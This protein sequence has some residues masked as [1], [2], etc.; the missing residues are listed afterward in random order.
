MT[1]TTSISPPQR[2]SWWNQTKT[3]NNAHGKNIIGREFECLKRV[4]IIFYGAEETKSKYTL[5]KAGET[6]GK[7]RHSVITHIILVEY[8]HSRLAS[9]KFASFWLAP[10]LLCDV[11]YV[12]TNEWEAFMRTCQLIRK[13]SHRAMIRTR[14]VVPKLW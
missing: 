6:P 14:P 12:T 4:H 1:Y 13:A 9:L 11:V 5:S 8:N 2:A 10:S 7:Q 3:R